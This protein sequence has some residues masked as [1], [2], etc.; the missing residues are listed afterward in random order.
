MT[1]EKEQEEE[2][3]EKKKEEEA[4]EEEKEELEALN[5][6]LETSRRA[7]LNNRDHKRRAMNRNALLMTAQNT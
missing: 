3:L 1:E 4:K 6:A 5:V 2:A 7:S